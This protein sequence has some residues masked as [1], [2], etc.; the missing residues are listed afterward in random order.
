M[1]WRQPFARLGREELQMLTPGQ[2]KFIAPNHKTLVRKSLMVGG[3]QIHTTMMANGSRDCQT[4]QTQRHEL[5]LFHYRV[6]S[7][8]D[9]ARKRHSFHN[10]WAPSAN[11]Q[12]ISDKCTRKDQ[13]RDRILASLTMQASWHG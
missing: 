1:V 7:Q 12:C 6:R 5:L 11:W 3:P 2:R 13:S 8:A 9:W 10:N 4:N